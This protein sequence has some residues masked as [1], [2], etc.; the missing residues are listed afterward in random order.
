MNTLEVQRVTFLLGKLE[1]NCYS[2]VSFDHQE[3]LFSDVSV[4]KRN[5]GKKLQE[6][7]KC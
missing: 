6:L 1:R 7:E 2:R 4:S 5:L 3:N